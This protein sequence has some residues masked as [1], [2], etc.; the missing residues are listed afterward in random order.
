MLCVAKQQRL[1]SAIGG[2]WLS[3]S[4]PRG[5]NKSGDSTNRGTFATAQL[6]WVAYSCAKARHLGLEFNQTSWNDESCPCRRSWQY[7]TDILPNRNSLPYHDCNSFLNLT[8]YSLSFSSTLMKESWCKVYIVQLS[9]IH[10][11]KSQIII[12]RSKFHML[13]KYLHHLILFTI[14]VQFIIK[15]EFKKIKNRRTNF[16]IMQRMHHILIFEQLEA[17]VKASYMMIFM[18]C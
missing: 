13:F 2:V 12:S 7:T 6:S 18:K 8:N 16:Y 11:T 3:V 1:G 17:Q 15:V 10:R 5:P 4:L 9:A 14:F